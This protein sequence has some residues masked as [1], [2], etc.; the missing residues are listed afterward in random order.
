MTKCG[1]AVVCYLLAEKASVGACLTLISPEE[2]LVTLGKVIYP[3]VS[4]LAGGIKSN[5]TENC[6]LMMWIRVKHVFLCLTICVCCVL[7]L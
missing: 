2:N 4:S 3:V 6:H 7:C 1:I 5:T